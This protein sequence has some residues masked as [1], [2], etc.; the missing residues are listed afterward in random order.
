MSYEVEALAASRAPTGTT[1]LTL[2]LKY[3]RIVLSELNTHRSHSKNSGSSR[4]IPT[5]K[6]L[7]QIRNDPAMPYRFGANQPGM[8]D[9]GE[10]HDGLVAIPLDLLPA[11]SNWTGTSNGFTTGRMFWKFMAHINAG[12]SEAFHDAGF[13]KQIGNRLTEAYQ[14]MNTIITADGPSWEHF[15]MLRDHEAADPTIAHLASMIRPV[16]KNTVYKNL[17]EGEWHMP[18]IAP[19]EETLDLKTRLILSSARSARVSYEPFDGV[20]SHEKET[21]R[22]DLLV[23]SFP[24]HMSPTEHQATPV[25]GRW[26]NFTNWR[27]YRHFLEVGDM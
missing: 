2:R 21:A 17:E 10:E 11:W 14:W 15:L 19:D 9:K 12:A 13:H 3:P 20:A 24:P 5:L 6:L 1:L 16:Y 23:R 18:Y 8:Q 27:Q 7:E 22:H 26:G 25:S 4:A